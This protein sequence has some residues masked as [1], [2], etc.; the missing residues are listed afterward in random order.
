[1]KIL[2]ALLAC[3]SLAL[4]SATVKDTV[5]AINPAMKQEIIN[6][7]ILSQVDCDGTD[8]NTKCYMVQK[9]ASIG[10]DFSEMLPQPIEGFRY[11]EGYTYDVT[12]K[13]DVTPASDGTST[14]KYTLVNV[15]S[16]VKID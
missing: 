9:G 16:K 11:E 7:R 3:F 6:M 5:S 12:V 8:G 4:T 2:F 13:I 1:M 10:K 14:F 15:L